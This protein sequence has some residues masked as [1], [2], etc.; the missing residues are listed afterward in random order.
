M[1]GDGILLVMITAPGEEHGEKI[2]KALVEDRLGACVNLISKIRS[3]FRWKGQMCEEEEVL[4]L[5][6]TTAESMERLIQRVKELHPYELPEII[7]LPIVKG[8]SDYLNW[9]RLET[10]EGKVD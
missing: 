10:M 9:V 7:A 6:K 2:A 1:D 4:L 3:F 5:I 8:L